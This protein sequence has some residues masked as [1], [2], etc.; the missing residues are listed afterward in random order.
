[1]EFGTE[2]IAS[3]E[4]YPCFTHCCVKW[5]LLVWL[6]GTFGGLLS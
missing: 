3:R 6:F 2:A 1:M 5:Q 4:K